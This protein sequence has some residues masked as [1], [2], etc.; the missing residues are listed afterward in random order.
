MYVLV[1]FDANMNSI[2]Y[3]QIVIGVNVFVYSI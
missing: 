3:M 1:L 2:F